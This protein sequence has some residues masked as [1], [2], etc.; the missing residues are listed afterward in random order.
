MSPKTYTC[1]CSTESVNQK[2]LHDS[3]LVL[4]DLSELTLGNT[5]A[6]VVNV[7]WTSTATNLVDPLAKHTNEQLLDVGLGEHLNTETISLNTSGVSASIL[8]HR[9]GKSGHRSLNRTRRGMRNVGT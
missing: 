9:H 4:Q 8:I 2:A 3:N 5:I 1:S 7:G 6:E